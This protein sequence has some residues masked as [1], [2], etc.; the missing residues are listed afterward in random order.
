MAGSD[1]Q[2][3]LLTLI[4][5]FTSEKSQGERRIVNQKKRI[6]ELRSEL[7]AA[8]AELVEAKRDRENTDQE[9]KGHEVEL[10]M[11]EASLQAL[12]S[13]NALVN[14]DVSALGGK[15]AELKSEENS[16]WDGF[17]ARM[18]ELNAAIRKFQEFIVSSSNVDKS[19][20][21]TPTGAGPL[22]THKQDGEQARLAL[23]NELAQMVL[24]TDQEEQQY[25]TEKEICSMLQEELSNL[26]RKAMLLE[27]VMK[28]SMELQELSKQ[29]SELEENC[30]AF[31]DELQKRFLCPRC[32]EDNS[33]E[34]GAIIQPSEET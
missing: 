20:Q 32:N 9:L 1:S 31:G 14:S 11:N 12:E 21:A 25:K 18:L 16:L 8:N 29:T 4:R 33:A 26:K 2:K 30:A 15:L 5:D 19:A 7:D 27:S 10:S 3:P 24:H 6:E 23:K 17:I 34:L 22:I 13:R 28:E